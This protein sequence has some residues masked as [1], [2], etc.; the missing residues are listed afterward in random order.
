MHSVLVLLYQPMKL[1]NVSV[2]L[3][4]MVLNNQTLTERSIVRVKTRGNMRAISMLLFCLKEGQ[5]VGFA[6]SINQTTT[7]VSLAHT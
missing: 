2:L 1:W 3:T 5:L 6:L 7:R 4:F